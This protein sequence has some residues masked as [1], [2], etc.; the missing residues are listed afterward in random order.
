MWRSLEGGVLY[1][2]L[3]RGTAFFRGRRSLNEI[4]Y[5]VF[6]KLINYDVYHVNIC[7]FNVF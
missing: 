2:I 5:T 3:V 7:S 4:R 1:K 6:L